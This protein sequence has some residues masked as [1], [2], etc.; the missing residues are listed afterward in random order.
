MFGFF[1]KKEPPQ[2]PPKWSPPVPH[3]RP[4]I[5][6]PL[7]AI[8][9]HLRFYTGGKRDFVAFQHG[10]CVVLPEGLSDAD[11]ECYAK[12]VLSK[13]INYHPD[14]QPAPMKDG[15]ILIQYNHPALNLVL[16]SVAQQ[17]W[18][19]IDRQHQRALTRDEVLHTPL[20]PNVFDDFGKK[21]LFGRC[22]LFMDALE[23][24]VVRISRG[25]G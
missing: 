11:A 21:A 24:K 2:E 9:E 6:Q 17:H 16:D 13:I 25:A 10:T 22:Y 19:E 1:K 4:D 5:Q 8:M 14:M 15:N 3:W 23:P 18:P 7:E 20:G 12:D